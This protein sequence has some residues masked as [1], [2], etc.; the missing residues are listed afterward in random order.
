ML[1]QTF[2]VFLDLHLD[3]VAEVG[4]GALVALWFAGLAGIATVQKQQMM[5]VASILVWGDCLK[6]LFYGLG[7]RCLGETGAVGD[8]EDMGVDG[9]GW[10]AKPEVQD[11]IRGFRP[12]T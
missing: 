8:P 3:L 6:L 2:V 5:G 4:N 11:N 9:D 12:D 1:F 10:F 7:S